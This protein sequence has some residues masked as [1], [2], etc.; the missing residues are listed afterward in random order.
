M[1]VVALNNAEGSF[2]V[3]TFKL[4][5]VADATIPVLKRNRSPL[6]N[7]EAVGHAELK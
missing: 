6:A 5:S 2:P 4:A 3:A 7:L 1:A